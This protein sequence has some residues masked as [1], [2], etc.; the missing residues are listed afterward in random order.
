MIQRG[1]IWI[2]WIGVIALAF[3]L[4]LDDL[5]ERPIHFD[6]ATG[7]Q[8]FS[9]RLEDANY[10]FDPTHYHGPFQSIIT[11]PIAKLYGEQSWQT[12][13]LPM[14]RTGPAIAGILL[15]LTPL[16]WLR[17]IGPP[18]ALAAGALLASSPLLVY[19]NRMYIHESWLAL[20]GMLT[21]A[22]VFHLIQGFIAVIKDL[23]L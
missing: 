19:Y 5:G 16:L 18:A 6:E 11:W 9:K 15:V 21:A 14:L 23:H 7:A 13:S 10:R 3:W 4:R 17:M 1:F 20:F 22:A 12:L 8:I 2:G